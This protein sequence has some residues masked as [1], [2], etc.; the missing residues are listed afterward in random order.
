M[1]AAAAPRWV[2][3]PP[4]SSDLTL[5]NAPVEQ[6]SDESALS[7]P[8]HK[9]SRLRVYTYSELAAIQPR[10]ALVD[11]LLFRGGFSGVVAP[12]DSYKSFFTLGL[13]LCIAH[14]L[15]FYDLRTTAG[16][17]VYQAGEGAPGIPPRVEAWRTLNGI[18]EIGNILFLPQSVKLNVARDLVDLLALL[19]GLPE[20]PAKVTIDTFAR[21]LRGNENSAEDTGLYVEAVDAIRETIGA[22]VGIVHHAG[23]EG[24]RSRGST[25]VPASLDTELTLAR[26][27]DRVTVSVTK[28]KDCAS[29]PP[30][31]LE[32]VPVAGSIAFRRLAVTTS[33]LSDAERKMM[34]ALPTGVTLG[35]EAWRKSADVKERTFFRAR[36]RLLTISY[37]KQTKEGYSATDAGR[38]A[39]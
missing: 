20:Q 4:F 11:D 12:Y 25:N 17:V 36:T 6:S 2:G 5:D 18:P 10:P 16:L 23:W 33:R 9:Q 30:F 13:D 34:N 39:P 24:S 29:L 32:A 38:C 26:D 21:S 14:G 3:A 35:A 19:R 27:G 15:D 22:H 31:T 1:T 8:A 28:Q 7:T 37:V